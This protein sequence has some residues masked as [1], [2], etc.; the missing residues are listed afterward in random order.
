MDVFFGLFRRRILRY[1]AAV[2]RVG[3]V[4]DGRSFVFQI[5]IEVFT[6]SETAP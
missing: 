4:T 3:T 1:L 6:P 2:A 5:I